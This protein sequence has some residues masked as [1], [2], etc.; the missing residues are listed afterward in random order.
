[1]S[2]KKK[3]QPIT[4][5]LTTTAI[6]MLVLSLHNSSTLAYADIH[7]DTLSEVIKIEEKLDGNRTSLVTQINGTTGDISN[8]INSLIIPTLSSIE[9]TLSQILTSIQ[10]LSNGVSSIQNSVQNISNNVNQ[11]ITLKTVSVIANTTA[12]TPNEQRVVTLSSDEFPI[13]VRTIYFKADTGISSEN[14]SQG[15]RIRY[16]EI[17]IND[18]LVNKPGQLQLMVKGSNN[19]DTE[20]RI[21]QTE[22]SNAML[23]RLFPFGTNGNMTM[24][25]ELDSKATSVENDGFEFEVIVVVEALTDANVSLDIGQ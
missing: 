13:V 20:Q 12:G 19:Q 25:L 15:E 5:I 18:G 11:T 9:N 22:A 14:L 6:L 1:M 2:G 10:N 16:D 17:R 7:N 8:Q 21:L 23:Q 4:I 24:N 3:N